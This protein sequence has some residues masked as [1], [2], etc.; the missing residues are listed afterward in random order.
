MGNTLGSQR[1]EDLRSYLLESP[2]IVVHSL[3]ATYK[4]FKVCFRLFSR[5]F[6]TLNRYSIAHMR[7]IDTG[8]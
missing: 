6:A 4:L 2:D 5:L 8:A 1:M 7:V 3:L